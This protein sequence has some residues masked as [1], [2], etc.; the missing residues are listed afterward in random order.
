MT[1]DRIL[2]GANKIKQSQLATNVIIDKE[3]VKTT[4]K[5]LKEN[6]KHIEREIEETTKK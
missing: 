3:L 1:T 2:V 5:D 6:Y 4:L